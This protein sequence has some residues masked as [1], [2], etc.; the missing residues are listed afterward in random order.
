M[1]V[2]VKEEVREEGSAVVTGV[3]RAG[4]GPFPGDGLDEAFG[5]AIGLGS[6]GPGEAMSDA[7]SETG[8]GEVFG[9]VGRAAVGEEAAD[10]NPMDLVEGDG[11]VEGAEDCGDFFV[12]G[13]AG[14]GE[15]GVIVDG[16]VE[17]FDAGAGAAAGAIAGGADVGTLGAAELLDVEVEELAGVSMFVTLDGRCGW[18]ERSEALEV[19]AAQPAWR[20]RSSQRRTV[21]S[22]TW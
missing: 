10:I 3:I 9:A 14:E 1:A 20:A 13:E 16:D 4:I 18:F 12:W 7:E 5:F 17:T 21:L 19:V 6:I 11:L 2:I 8:G 15:A 22:L